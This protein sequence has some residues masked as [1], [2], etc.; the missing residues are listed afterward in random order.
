MRD[1]FLLL[2]KKAEKE[3][4]I[5]SAYFLP[6]HEIRKELRNASR[7]GVDVRIIIP[8]NTDVKTVYYARRAMYSKTLRAGIKIYE[9]TP[10]VLH[11]KMAIVDRTTVVIGSA[12]FDYR[13]FIHNIEGNIFVEGGEIGEDAYKIFKKDMENSEEVILE[14]FE[15]RSFWIK[16][17]EWILFIFRYLL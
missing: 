14:E 4:F 2:I 3:I 1:A 8:R 9:Y 6:D 17:I 15:K 10:H 13:S 16:I 7:R 12:N 5:E 11:T